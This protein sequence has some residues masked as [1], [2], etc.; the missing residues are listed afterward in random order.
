MS[1][2]TDS[3]FAVLAAATFGAYGV[4]LDQTIVFWNREAERILGYTSQEMLGRHCYEALS[5]V[6][7]GGDQAQCEGGCPAIQ[8][9]IA[10][11]VPSQT[12][13]AMITST[14]DRKLVSLTPVV[15]GGMGGGDPIVL[16]LFTE[17]AAG[18]LPDGLSGATPV[19]ATAPSRRIATEGRFAGTAASGAPRLT[20][21]EVEVLRLVSGGWDT[22]RIAN[23]L[24][25][26][27]H[28]VLNHIRHFRRK[29]DAP[30]K[31][32]AVVTAIRLGI[33]PID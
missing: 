29:L 20:S 1:L 22:P 17:E 16:H 7:S 3:I 6:V 21:R 9:L 5:G 14:G 28:T 8:D 11:S 26:S 23:E 25:I 13:T 30:T 33:L 4:S 32:D 24:N 2:T 31:L 18:T 27:P 15:I 12:S 19:E 10:G